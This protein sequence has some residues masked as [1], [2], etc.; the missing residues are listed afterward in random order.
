MLKAVFKEKLK[1][2]KKYTEIYE[3]PKTIINIKI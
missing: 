1:G 3:K 2:I